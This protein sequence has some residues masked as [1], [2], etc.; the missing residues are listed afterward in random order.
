MKVTLLLEDVCDALMMIKYIL[1][2]VGYQVVSFSDI[3][4]VNQII[5]INP[6]IILIDHRLRSGSGAEL[7]SELKANP[8]FENVPIVLISTDPEIS[9]IANDS[10]ADAYIAKPFGIEDLIH[11][12]CLVDGDRVVYL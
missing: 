4:P 10:Y 8:L 12:V 2:D 7:C 5:G 11:A 1:E 9:S 3:I 6:D